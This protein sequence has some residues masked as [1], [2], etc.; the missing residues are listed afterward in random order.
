MR[1]LIIGY[2]SIGKRHAKI[3]KDLDCYVCLVTSQK[4]EDYNSYP[5]IE[6]ALTKEVIDWVIISN[7]THLHH[8]SLLQLIKNN[9]QGK[10]LVEKP[11]FLEMAQLPSNNISKILLAYNLRFCNLLQAAKK[12]IENEKIITF[13]AY[14][15]SYLP[16]WRKGTDYRNC[17]SS[18][19][20]QGGGVLR[21]LSH[22]LDY[23][24]WF[25][26]PCLDVTASGGKFSQ[27]EIN[28]DDVY[29][30]LMK[31]KLCPLV[32]IQMNYVDHHPRREVMINTDRTSISID[33]VQGFLKVN[34]KIEMQSED[35]TQTYVKQHQA[36]LENDFQ[37]FCT[38]EEGVDLVNLIETI[39]K[40][41]DAKTW[42]KMDYQKSVPAIKTSI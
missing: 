13:S 33:L 6:I 28:S 7:P 36:L 32:N 21:D 22:E 15:G 8:E 11:L 35:R 29:S 17:Y 24:L 23:A 25:C 5:T 10:V 30:I 3:L 16:N 12:I 42:L 38:Y 39:E 37:S 18:H 31:T 41:N 20:D 27:L 19:R 9:Y 2:G 34:G 26:G 14:V 1:Y 40:A 4:I